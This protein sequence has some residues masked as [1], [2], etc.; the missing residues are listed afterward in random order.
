[1]NNTSSDIEGE[2]HHNTAEKA[3]EL[4]ES[5]QRELGIIGPIGAPI[6]E[7]PHSWIF[8]S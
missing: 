7:M 4:L 5:K 8:L 2:N 3:K 6:K 1:M